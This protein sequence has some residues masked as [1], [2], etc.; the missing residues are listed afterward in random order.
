MQLLLLLLLFVA[1]A[2]SRHALK[3]G[4]KLQGVEDFLLWTKP[5]PVQQL[6]LQCRKLAF[7]CHSSTLLKRLCIQV[8]SIHVTIIL[9]LLKDL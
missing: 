2:F 9:W 6:L 1:V 5:K 7:S 4:Q 8:T 3:D